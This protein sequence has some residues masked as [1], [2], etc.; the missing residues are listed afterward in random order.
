MVSAVISG[1]KAP[2][3]PRRLPSKVL[4]WSSRLRSPN[5]TWEAAKDK[6]STSPKTLQPLSSDT[7][8]PASPYKER[9]RNG[10]ILYP[11][12]LLFVQDAPTSPL[13]VG[14]G[15][16]AVQS[17]RTRM[18]NPPWKDLPSLTGVVERGFVRQVHMGE[19]L[20]HY[21]TLEPLRA[22]LPITN[23]GI[24]T[25]QQVEDHAGLAAWWNEVEKVWS[26][27]RVANETANLLDRMNYH[28]QF[29]AQLPAARHRVLYSKAGNTLAAA[30]IDSP[31]IIVENA[32][33][34]AAVSSVAEARYLTAILNSATILDR[35]RPLQALG[36]FGGRHF[37]K[38]VFAIPI[39]TFDSENNRHKDLVN[40]AASAEQ[41]AA[42][43]DIAAARNFVAARKLIRREL[44]RLGIGP[45]IEELVTSI[46]PALA[47]DAE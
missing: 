46:V 21:R 7:L 42:Q 35:V 39:P 11:R 19:S 8:P 31:D 2:N 9:F 26:A 34:W 44:D 17:R 41:A 37:D 27:H 29:S 36:L 40:L 45:A 12:L 38:N 28:N 23:T 47:V 24:L 43:L 16:L 18:E 15:R 20:L 13:G 10:A 33:Y 4:A 22:V 5:M 14:A 3:S 6:F 1:R 25:Q 32:L 30:R